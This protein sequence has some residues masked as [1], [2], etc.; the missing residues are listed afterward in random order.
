MKA[1]QLL[2]MVIVGVLVNLSGCGSNPEDTGVVA[3]TL[4]VKT[5]TLNSAE[6]LPDWTLTGVVTARYQTPL[7][8]RVTGK[9]TE[10]LVNDGDTVQVGQDLF[11]L[12]P[13]DFELSLN[14]S[15][16][17]IRS[18][19]SEMT[20][21]KL[22]LSRLQQLFKRNLTSEQ[23]VDQA[24]NTLT[25]LQERLKSQILQEKQARNQLAYTHLKSPGLGKISAVLAEKGQV[26]NAGT[27]AL[28]WI[29]N[30][31]R[32]IKV[33]VPE[34]RLANLPKTAQWLLANDQMVEV[35][36]REVAQQA[37]ANS[38]TWS[39][40]YALPETAQVIL[41]Q[42]ARLSF[43][44]TDTQIK[45]PNTAIYDQGQVTAIWSLVDGK[46]QRVPVTVLQLS[47]RFAWITG[48]FSQV[49][50]IVTLGVHQLQDGQM[51]R[52]SAQ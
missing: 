2:G 12:D 39:A 33:Q 14:V 3:S 29:Q 20:N 32:E 35:T 9:I 22:E 34:N 10:R 16:A 11:K 28:T 43:T 47:D 21:A 49:Q 7:A 8:F 44:A 19:E 23:N 5:Q 25:V 13:T 52:E 1:Q 36:L 50:K 51:V 18:T 17:N 27:P 30:G 38:R 45:V 24:S 31:H 4:V 41:G 37:D 6:T 26:I 40:Y 48:D 46:V 15:L 42:T